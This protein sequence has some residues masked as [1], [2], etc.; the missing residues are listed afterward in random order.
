MQANQPYDVLLIEAVP[1]LHIDPLHVDETFTIEGIMD[2][3]KLYAYS[4]SEY[5]H[6]VEKDNLNH[7]EE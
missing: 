2:N 7:F 6:L 3:T 4:E 5:E 1:G